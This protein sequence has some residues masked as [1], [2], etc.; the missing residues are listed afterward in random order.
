[1]VAY[2][3]LAPAGF[4]RVLLRLSQI[5][6]SAIWGRFFMQMGRNFG[7]ILGQFATS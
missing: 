3:G 4:S 5:D 2:L 7:K 6:L 1:M